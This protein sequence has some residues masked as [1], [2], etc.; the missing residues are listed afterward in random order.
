MRTRL[1]VAIGALTSGIALLAGCTGS[2]S[3]QAVLESHMNRF[4]T[5]PSVSGTLVYTCAD[6]I[7]T[8]DWFPLKRH[9]IA[10]MLVSPDVSGNIGVDSL[11]NVYITGRDSAD[12]EVFP[13]GSSTILKTLSDPGERPIDVA[14]A[15]DGTVYVAS[16]QN[17][18]G[19]NGSVAVFQSGV[20]KRIISDPNFHQVS[21]VAIDEHHLLIVCWIN[22]GTGGCDEFPSAKGSGISVISGAGIFPGGV[23]FDKNE[24]IVI[25]NNSSLQ[26]YPPSGG[27]P[28]NTIPLQ[29]SPLF[30]AFDRSQTHFFYADR[31]NDAIVEETYPG[32]S[33]TA[34][35]VFT[36]N[37]GWVPV[38]VAVD[39]G[40]VP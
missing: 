32:C 25:E 21:S 4:S 30:F 1:Q 33:G 22:G 14:I 36:Y 27:S 11:G 34:S 13:K 20:L 18:N 19:G 39:L 38:G 12:I 6:G 24:N 37:T 31:N 2:G 15:G 29:N 7:S 16:S 9:T 26:V 3:T 23:K 35:V 5:H 40:P 28:C 8:C 10:G 17:L